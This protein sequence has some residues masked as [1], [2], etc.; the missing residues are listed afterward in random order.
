VSTPPPPPP[1][2]YGGQQPNPY[3][4]Q[5]PQNPYGGGP[6]G[7]YP[8]YG[9]TPPK[10]TNGMAIASL[11]VSL[12]G[13]VTCGVGGLVGAILGH[14]AKRQI[15]DR[16][17]AGDGLALAGIIIGWIV[18]VLGLAG[19]ILYVVFIVWAVNQGTD[20]SYDSQGYYTCS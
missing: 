4:G 18:F 12:V 10:P 5:P 17:Q 19:T 11:V 3:G 2:P 15:R 20:C 6:Y 13:L 7:G 1:D 9:Y 16:D 14:V 8:G